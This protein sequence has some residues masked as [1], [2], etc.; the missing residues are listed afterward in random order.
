MDGQTGFWRVVL[1]TIGGNT[2]PPPVVRQVNTLR[3]NGA[4]GV[5][6]VI[7]PGSAP[8]YHV[9]LVPSFNGV[10]QPDAASRSR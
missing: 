10:S 8:V 4:L 5:S 7:L 6:A 9:T 2:P 3:S 1:F